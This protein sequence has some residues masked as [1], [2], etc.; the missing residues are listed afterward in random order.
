MTRDLR[1]CCVGDS[2]VAGVGDPLCLGWV[3]RLA[4]GTYR[5]GQP[6]TAYNLGVRRQT[7]ADVRARWEA[8]CEQRLRDGDD[9]RVALSFGVNDAVGEAGRPRVAAADSAANLTRILGR[10]A[11]RGWPALVI[12][13]TPVADD[14][15]NARTAVLDERFAAVCRSAAVPYVPVHRAL[16]EGAAWMREVRAGDGAHPSAKGYDEIAALVDPYWR[17]WLSG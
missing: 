7:S 1:I 17:A 10:A 12:G 15:T 16:R 11:E 9:P 6:L 14:D 3:G 5:A 8:E 4:A 13:P 2:L